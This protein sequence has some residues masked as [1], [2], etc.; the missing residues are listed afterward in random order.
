MAVCLAVSCVCVCVCVCVF[1]KV[2]QLGRPAGSA[3][4]ADVHFPLYLHVMQLLYGYQL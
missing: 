4:A 2:L 1:L 3:V